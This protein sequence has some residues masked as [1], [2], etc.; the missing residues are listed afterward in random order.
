MSKIPLKK[1]T[2]SAKFAINI[3][4]KVPPNWYENSV[5]V[6]IFQRFWHNRRFNQLKKNINTSS[7]IFLDVGCCDGFLTKFILDNSLATKIYGIDV[8]QESVNYAI[9]RYRNNK[10]LFFTYGDAHNIPFK[11]KSFDVIFCLDVIE[12]LQKPIIALTEMKR[13]LKNNGIIFILV[14]TNSLVF[15]LCWFFWT[16]WRGK[17]WRGTHIN[18]FSNTEIINLIKKAGFK[19]KTND[20]FLLGMYQLVKCSL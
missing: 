15:R 2:N 11:D 20:H 16:K 7:G 14:H 12:H 10:K 19:I 17:I 4:N 8:L 1:I 3:H 18:I 9:K 5:Q 13:V 6:N